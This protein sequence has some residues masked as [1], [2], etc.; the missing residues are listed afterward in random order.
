MTNNPKIKFIEDN[1]YP[2][3]K[4]FWFKKSFSIY[5]TVILILVS[6]TAGILIG[7][8]YGHLKV[9]TEP[10]SVITEQGEKFG[11][12]VDKNQPLPDYLK[13]DINFSL[14]WEVWNKIQTEYIDRPVGE[15]KLLYGALNGL[16]ASLRDPYSMFLEPEPAKEFSQE[17]QGYFEGIGAEIGIRDNVLTIISPLSDS[18]AESAG[19]KAG[20]KVVEIDGYD[21]TDISL[22][23]AVNR[24]RGEKGTKVVLKIFREK[25]GGF[26]E[27]S[28]IRDVIEIVSVKWEMKDNNIAYIKI[29]N[30]NSDTDLRFKKAVNQI[31]LENPKA[32]ILD[33]RN[34]PGGYLDQAISIAS[35]WLER[36]KVVVQ[37]E[38][39]KG[40]KKQ[41]LADGQT[42]FKDYPT[43]ILINGGS[44]SGSEIVAGALQ[45]NKVAKLVG[46]KTFGKGSVQNLVQLSDGSAIKL[47]IA[48][49]LTP[50]GRQ[51]DIEK[52]EPDE[53]VEFSEEDF[54]A[55]LDPQLERA[56]E[57]LSS[58]EE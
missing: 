9:V 13:E 58:E 29:T 3:Q 32:I 47:T 22:Q 19:L 52:I 1:I 16:I 55:D 42:E 50:N 35:Y 12:V 5:V 49:W 44:A 20:D 14:F 33:L 30:F 31:L 27:M 15:T 45:D 38:L 37:E 11:K 21:T 2:H 57:I 6:F 48:R 51:I 41:Y 26:H 18:P 25:D 56:L 34:N 17:L 7:K 4:Q 28:V 36:G 40:N 46:E 54:K 10:Q 23:E 53:V 24:I 8:K 39:T 43:V